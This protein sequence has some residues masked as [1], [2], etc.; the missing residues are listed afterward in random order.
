MKNYRIRVFGKV[1]GVFYRASTLKVASELG[2]S[3]WVR[4]E[5]DGSVLISAEAE[6]DQLSKLIEWCKQGPDHA[7]VSKV[8]INERDLENYSSFRIVR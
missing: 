3:G 1:Q 6:E 4:N 7:I 8:D 5:D 2:I